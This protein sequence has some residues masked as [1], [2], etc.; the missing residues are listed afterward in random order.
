MPIITPDGDRIPVPARLPVIPLRDVVFFPFVA[1]P[2]IVGRGASLAAVDAA[3]E[4]TGEHYLFVVSQRSP[5]TDEPAAGDLH[6]VGV[7]V[8][9]LEHARLPNG[10]SRLLLEGVARARVA[11]YSTAGGLLRASLA[12][13]R[14]AAD[15][16][17]AELR[18]LARRALSQFEEYVSLHR[19]IPG[20]VVA[21][22]QGATSPA[23][24]AYAIAA[25]LAVPPAARQQ[26][27]DAE[28]LGALFRA[29]DAAIAGEI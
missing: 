14:P 3:M 1:M 5:D 19:R 25:H 24:Q 4:G 23:R 18:A 6:R 26:L 8:R 21:I 15:V 10:T 28:P 9:V 11:R 17:A 27:L 29:L 2:L 20:E 16:P 22:A 7:V 12:D 13:Q